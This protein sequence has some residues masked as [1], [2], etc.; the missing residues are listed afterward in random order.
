MANGPTM[1]A[2]E[3]PP[4][5]RNV[6]E[7]SVAQARQAFDGFMSAAQKAVAKLEDQ[8]AAAQAGAKGASQRIVGYAEKNV[9]ASFDFAQRLARA[10]DVQEMMKLQQEFMQ[11]QMQALAEQAKEL[12][13][14]ATKAATDAAKGKGPG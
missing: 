2:F 13:Q 8:T 5:M 4:E 3:I 12:G 1:G 7:Q 14:T 9:A 10:K 6:A 11:A